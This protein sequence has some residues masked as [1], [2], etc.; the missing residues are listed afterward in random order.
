MELTKEFF[1]ETIKS[2]ATKKDLESL[3]SEDELK[4]LRGFLSEHMLTKTEFAEIRTQLADKNDV[5]QIL[6]SVDGIAKQMATYNQELPAI[7]HQLQT[8]TDWIREASKK[9]GVEYRP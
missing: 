9:I 5:N 4:T 1:Q 6:T 3:A 7:T 8:I 2:L